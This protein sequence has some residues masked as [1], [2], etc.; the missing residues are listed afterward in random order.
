MSQIVSDEYTERTLHYAFVNMIKE[1]RKNKLV[2]KRLLDS[3]FMMVES[4]AVYVV[5]WMSQ[6]SF[7]KMLEYMKLDKGTSRVRLALALIEEEL[8]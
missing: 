1:L 2:N 4:L 8:E 7:D 6:E 3:H 5:E